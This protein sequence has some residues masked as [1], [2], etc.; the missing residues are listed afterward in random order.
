M[1]KIV[2]SFEEYKGIKNVECL[3][4]KPRGS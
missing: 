4:F 2:V 3:K 1:A